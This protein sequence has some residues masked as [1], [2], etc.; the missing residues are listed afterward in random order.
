MVFKTDPWLSCGR[1]AALALKGPPQQV[2]VLCT[3][4]SGYGAVSCWHLSCWSPCPA[5]LGVQWPMVI[6]ILITGGVDYELSYFLG[7]ERP[8]EFNK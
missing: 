2:T 7:L 3:L 1:V 6:K 5:K 4:S 8:S